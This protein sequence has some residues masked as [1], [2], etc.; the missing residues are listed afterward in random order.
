MSNYKKQEIMKVLSKVLWA[1]DFDQDHT[2]SIEKIRNVAKQ[3]GS[4][5]ILLHILPGELNK[6]SFREVVNKSI[7]A[8]LEAVREKLLLT[9]EYSIRTRIEFGNVVDRILDVSEEEDVNIIF[10]NRGKEEAGKKVALGLNAQKIFRNAHKPVALVS[11]AP[12]AEKGHIV[13][14]VDTSEPSARALNS[15]ILH[16]KKT[17]SR[18]TV[19]SVFEPI[20]ISSSRLIN[21]GVDEKSEN[22]VHFNEFTKSFKEFIEGFD[23][24]GLD[25][26]TELIW[27]TPHLEIIRYS[28]EATIL[29]MGSTGKTG[30]RRAILGSVTERVT[31]EVECNVVVLKSVEVFKLR[32]STDLED[33]EKHFLR[34]YK[35]A[36]LGFLEEAISQYKVCLQVNDLHLPSLYALSRVYENL[37]DRQQA[38]YYQEMAEI[39]R[40][41]MTDWKIEEEIRGHYLK[42]G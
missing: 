42:S 25:F 7:E 13:C 14:P 15:A 37:G 2:T 40:Q 22:K 9:G 6:S 16:A 21:A 4:E 36:E 26:Q 34:A 41:R 28:Q 10:I 12:P 33:I 24:T 38:E 20:R 30:L 35:L 29:Y 19:I 17:N 23:F 27:G 1:I 39:V 5:I 32:I 11:E 3:F 31:G 8:E 18:L